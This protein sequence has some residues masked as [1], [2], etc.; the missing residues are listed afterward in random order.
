MV[1]A[2]LTVDGQP[3]GGSLFVSPGE[4]ALF[5]GFYKGTRYGHTDTRAA[6][7]EAVTDTHHVH[8]HTTQ[9][10]SLRS[11]QFPPVSCRIVQARQGWE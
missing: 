8:V 11:P 10:S 3:A 7:A 1:Q 5:T 6:H 2:V 4:P 9:L